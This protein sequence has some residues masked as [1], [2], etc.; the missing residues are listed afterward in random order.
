MS[1]VSAVIAAG[2]SGNRMQ[3]Q[4]NKVYLPINGLPLL[5][6]TLNVFAVCHR[7]SEIVVVV[8]K[9]EVDYCFTE[10]VKPLGLSKKVSITA[11]GKERQDSVRCGLEAASATS[12]Y[13]VVHDGARPLLTLGLLEAVIVEAFTTGAA[14]AAVPVKDTIKI[15]DAGGFVADTPIRDNLW[16]VQ[17]PQAFKKDILLAAHELAYDKRILGTDDAF[18]VEK[19]GHPVKI[20]SGDYEN[21][22]IT[23]P[24]DLKIA[25]AVLLG[26]ESAG[27]SRHRLRYP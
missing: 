1:K 7:I 3:M 9:A 8:P 18:L 11:G 12:D 2:G 26:R 23:T 25:E 13:V 10:V 21:I 24:E 4:V 15:A 6:H 22:K 17:T 27:E 14:I 16:S 20:V 19:L 5:A